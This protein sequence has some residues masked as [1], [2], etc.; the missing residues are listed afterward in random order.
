MGYT[1]PWLSITQSGTATSLRPFTSGSLL[2][3]GGSGTRPY[4]V[5]ENSGDCTFWLGS[6]RAVEFVDNV[7]Q[8]FSIKYTTPDAILQ[9]D[10]TNNNIYLKPN[11]TGKV[12]FGTKTG[13]GD[14]AV[15]GYVD[16]LDS[17]GNAVKLATVA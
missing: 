4:L 16:I 8:F 5:I 3:Y 1:P 2:I 12:K 11:G 13:T 9:V 6:G 14:V 7:T 10:S 17:A 15:D